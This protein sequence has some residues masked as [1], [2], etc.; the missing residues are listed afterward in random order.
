MNSII[1]VIAVSPFTSLRLTELLVGF[2]SGK[3]FQAISIHAIVKTT[4][5]SKVHLSPTQEF[6][7]FNGCNRPTNAFF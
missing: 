2:G 7:S 6:H 1:V 5:S 3:R 4:W